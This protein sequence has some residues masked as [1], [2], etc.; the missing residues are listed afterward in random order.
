[1]TGLQDKR[2]EFALMGTPSR[3]GVILAA[4]LTLAAALMLGIVA[5]FVPLGVVV[6]DQF[7]SRA[8]PS[9]AD[10]LAL[11]M[12]VGTLGLVLENVALNSEGR[13]LR[14]LA[15]KDELTGIS[16]RR[17]ILDLLRREV[18]R[19]RRY[20]KPLALALVDVD[21]FKSWN[22]LHGHAVGDMVLQS[23]AQIITSASR[24]IDAYG[25]YGGEEFLIVL[26]ET[27]ADHAVAAGLLDPVDLKSPGIYDLTLLNEVLA[28]LGEPAAS[29]L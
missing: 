19:A 14:A 18:D 4:T 9:I 7:V 13:T 2:S 12:A 16:N 1:M 10:A 29:A 25:R 15:E 22:D 8:E 17:N 24:E 28:E 5:M 23:V 26:P 21:H 11:S 6:V 27:S 3:G 20:G